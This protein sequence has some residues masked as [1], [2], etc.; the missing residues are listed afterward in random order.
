MKKLAIF[1]AAFVL[2]LGLAQCKKEQPT[3]QNLEGET[4]YL[5]VNV[6]NNGSRADITNPSLSGH[7]TFKNGDLLYVGYN[8]AYV[9]TL[10]YNAETSK[11][12]GDITLTQVGN[13]PLH[14]YYLGGDLTPTINGTR[15][16]VNISDQST[17]YPVISYGASTKNYSTSRNSY[18]TV[19]ENQCALVKFTYSTGTT[20]SVSVAGMKNTATIDFTNPGVVTPGGNG[21]ITLH[22]VNDTEKWA[23]LLEQGKVDKAWCSRGYAHAE[24]R[25]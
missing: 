22:S 13:Q 10:S 11:F 4:V 14:F 8:N 17:N 25:R 7:Y 15:Y 20:A 19:L 16:T 9:G 24:E 5:T 21:A 3:A 1:V 2:T 12:G 23:I 18:T 6:G